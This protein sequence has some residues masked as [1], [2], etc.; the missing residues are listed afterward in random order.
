MDT[1]L[2]CRAAKTQSHRR[3]VS[4]ALAALVFPLSVS[5]ASPVVAVYSKTMNGYSRTL[6]PDNRY[7]PETYAFADGGWLGGNVTDRSIDNLKFAQV[8]GVVAASLKRQN[9]IPTTDPKS[10]NLLIFVSFGT[11]NGIDEKA[12]QSSLSTLSADFHSMTHPI[13]LGPSSTDITG[14]NI[15]AEL[16]EAAASAMDSTFNRVA[17][18]NQVRFEQDRFNAGVLGYQVAW[19]ETNFLR[20][21][22]VTARDIL[23]EIEESRYFVVLQAYDFQAL[24]NHQGKKLLWETRYSIPR[25]GARFDEQIVD[26]TRFAAQ[27]CGQDAGRLIRRPLRE[28][29]VEMGTPTEVPVSNAK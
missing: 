6:L 12:Y 17:V 14:I 16:N 24:R 25:H 19:D 10:A 18:A 7:K 11:T 8:A 2:L 26:M 4:A 20:P 5:A 3:F 28:G 21:Y 27:F 15:Q 9:Y 23:S 13:D 22:S 1:S 29:R